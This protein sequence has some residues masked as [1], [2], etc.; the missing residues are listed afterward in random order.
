MPELGDEII[1]LTILRKKSMFL[2]KLLQNLL[3]GVVMIN[4]SRKGKGTATE[5]QIFKRSTCGEK[6]SIAHGSI[7]VTTREETHL[8]REWLD[9]KDKAATWEISGQKEMGE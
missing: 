1:F 5:E 8:C 9:L 6:K 4:N 2:F 3:Y 7:D